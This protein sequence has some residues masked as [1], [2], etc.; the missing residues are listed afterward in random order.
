M[1]P[2]ILGG[3]VEVLAREEALERRESIE[4]RPVKEALRRFFLRG[5][6]TMISVEKRARI[7][8]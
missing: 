8:R 6:T 1:L 5:S 7:G 3:A 4:H 2:E